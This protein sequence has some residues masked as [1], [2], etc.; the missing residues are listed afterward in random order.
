MVDYQ[1]QTGTCAWR[2]STACRGKVGRCL[3]GEVA[4]EPMEDV[5]TKFLGRSQTSSQFSAWPFISKALKNGHTAGT[6]WS[7][8]GKESFQ[9]RSLL[10]ILQYHWQN[11]L[12]WLA[13]IQLYKETGVFQAPWG[14]VNQPPCAAKL[15]QAGKTLTSA[16]C[17]CSVRLW[18]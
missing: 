8:Q 2:F 15:W 13:K 3:Q 14:P 1:K 5:Y 4:G 10:S 11:T 16:S 9:K 12:Y 6:H 7:L 18:H 17:S